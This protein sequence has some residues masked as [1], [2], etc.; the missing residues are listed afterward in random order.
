MNDLR[1]IAGYALRE[2][3]RRRVLVVVVVLTAGFL[4][5]YAFGVNEA[6]DEVSHQGLPPGSQIEDTVLTG[7]TLLGLAMFVTLFLGTVLAVF[8]TLNAVRGDAERG[9]LQPLVVRPVGRTTLLLARFVA[10]AGVCVVYVASV[11]AAALIITGATGGYWPDNPVSGGLS[12]A[13]AVIVVVALA[14]L[15]TTL[16]SSTANGIAIFMVFGA[17]LAAG[18]L[19][20]IGSALDSETLERI[21]SIASWALP[22]EALY[23]DGLH[24]LTADIGGVTGVIVQLGPFGGAQNAGVLLYPYVVA[25]LVAVGLVADRMFRR[26]D[27]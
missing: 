13:G 1:I 25:Y 26:A 23:Q 14:L 17:G 9:L 21:S 3:V 6:F 20:Q 5:L 16:L 10:G 11:Y 22:F 27:L 19:G 8:L 7:A 12:L 4:A 15:G 24:A 2:A 18:L